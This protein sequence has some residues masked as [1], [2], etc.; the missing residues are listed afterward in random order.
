MRHIFSIGILLFFSISLYSKEAS[1]LISDLMPFE[2][3][4]ED[5]L[6]NSTRITVR[7]QKT[8]IKDLIELIGR[9]AHINFVLDA[10]VSG[11]VEKIFLKDCTPGHILRVLFLSNNPPLTLVKEKTIWRI[12]PLEKALESYSLLPEDNYKSSIIE[13]RKAKLDEGFKKKVEAVFKQLLSPEIDAQAYFTLD[14]DNRKIFI[15]ARQ[16]VIDAFRQYIKEADEATSQVRIDAIIVIADRRYEYSWGFDWSGI[17]NRIQT[18]QL[19]EKDF[20]F[21]GVGGKLKNFKNVVTKVCPKPFA[22]NLVT[23]GHQLV[24]LPFV[25]GGPNLNTQRLNLVLRAAEAEA[26][27]KIVSRP[28]VLTGNLETA[29]ILIGN[30]IPL[31]VATEDLVEGRLR[32]IDTVSYKDVGTLI[33][34]TPAINK[35][36]ESIML[37]IIV[38]DSQVVDFDEFVAS[39]D[40][41]KTP[42]IIK[43]IRTR[44]RV[45]LG[46]NTTTVIGGLTL[47]K[48][49]VL[50]NSVPFLARIPVIGPLFFRFQ[51]DLNR[52]LEQLIFITPSIVDGV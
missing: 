13:L 21:I 19:K 30:N 18:V 2:K 31:P 46:K 7:S 17:Y 49:D 9:A 50:C 35:Y 34:V 6:L 48:R 10:G 8:D 43:T 33:R 25:F 38:E 14:P 44:N 4:F 28:S 42:P 1:S 29:E 27:L 32:N 51:S 24:N 47:N 26:K 36:N 45:V 41:L 12:L 39:K 11:T 3:F 22:F 40:R 23:K 15:Y 16:T 37:D 5:P 52:D 20:S